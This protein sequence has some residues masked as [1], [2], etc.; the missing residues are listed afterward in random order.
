ML[1]GEIKSH[2]SRS[3]IAVVSL[4]W[5]FHRQRSAEVLLE[6]CL[7]THCTSL[8]AVG[9]WCQTQCLCGQVRRADS[10][11]VRPPA[12]SWLSALSSSPA[13]WE[14]RSHPH[15]SNLARSCSLWSR[16][17]PVPLLCLNQSSSVWKEQEERTHF[18]LSQV[19]FIYSALLVRQNG[20]FV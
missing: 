1:K 10:A 12:D 7:W 13:C 19:F 17:N 3:I 15:T 5:S 16:I 6:C 8:R 11:S 9:C 18:S 14:P 20:T 2:F 4:F